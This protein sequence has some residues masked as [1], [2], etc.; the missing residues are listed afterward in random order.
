MEEGGAVSGQRLSI[1]P[2]RA[3]TDRALK[4]RD[5]QV[6][7]VLG[8][9]TDDLGWCRRSQVKM[10][11]EMDCARATVFEAIERLVKAGYLERHVQ[12]SE[13][14]RD[15]AHVY[16]VILDPVHPDVSKVRERDE[17][18]SDPCRYVGTPAGMSAP[19]A[20]PEAAPPAGS[21]PAPINDP[22][23]TTPAN[24]EKERADENE[25][26]PKA[27]ERGFKRAYPQW[28][29]HVTDS[30]PDA[31]KAWFRLIPPERIAAV[32]RM[33]D[34][35][36]AARKVKGRDY[37]CSFAVYL[38][39]KRWE[40]LPARAVAPVASAVT[41]P[42]FGPVWSQM[43]FG[44]LLGGPVELGEPDTTREKRLA[45]YAT[46]R[47]MIG[48]EMAEASYR[49]MGHDIGA[50]GELIFP[51]DFEQRVWREHVLANGYPKLKRLDQLAAEGRGML[52]PEG[53]VPLPREAFVAVTPGSP[54]YRAW[55]AEFERRMWPWIPE[56]GR[57]PVVYFPAGGPDGLSA[58]EAAMRGEQRGESDDG[59][60]Q[61]A[62]E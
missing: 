62:A 48:P 16:R 14:G 34:Y 60:G 24:Q 46:A 44:S 1:I 15:S 51:A 2:A 20:G 3:A 10:A 52:P 18:A 42:P 40:K 58:F 12:E 21:G 45:A 50:D 30:E 56:P 9:H 23:L 57:Q 13:S 37:V 27:I 39:E 49:R 54:T 59:V 4:P 22:S 55:Q 35:L 28:P 8:R 6:L 36:D 5:L 31:R 26:N 17:T 33:G 32:E 19:P 7:C 43:R 11:E 41:A 25:E 53:F 38:R 29:S 47:S 61:Q